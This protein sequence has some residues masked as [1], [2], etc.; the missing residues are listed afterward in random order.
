MSYSIGT[1]PSMP[2]EA[3]GNLVLTHFVAPGAPGNDARCIQLYI[4]KVQPT[5]ELPP[6]AQLDMVRIRALYNVLGKI[7]R[8][9]RAEN[10]DF[11]KLIAPVSNRFKVVSVSENTNSFG[12]YGMLLMSE[13]GNLW[14]VG[15]N[16]HNLLIKGKIITV[17]IGSDRKP[18][19]APFGFEIPELKGTASAEA[20]AEVWKKEAPAPGGQN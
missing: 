12:L 9:E 16:S 7:I 2:G 19:F 15:A 17:P 14:Q 6:L 5:G 11:G 13:D 1:I 18:D 3:S 4:Q 10:V 20:V 8:G